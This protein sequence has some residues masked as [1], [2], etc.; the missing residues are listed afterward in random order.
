MCLDVKYM[1]GLVGVNHAVSAFDMQSFRSVVWANDRQTSVR[2]LDF[3]GS[4]TRQTNTHGESH[5]DAL[6]WLRFCEDILR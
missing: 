2:I 4:L 5:N 3:W 1:R 6:L